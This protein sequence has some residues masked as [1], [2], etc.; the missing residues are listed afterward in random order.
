MTPNNGYCLFKRK[1]SVLSSSNKANEF[2][3]VGHFVFDHVD[4]SKT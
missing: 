4:C 1:I 3:D 2:K